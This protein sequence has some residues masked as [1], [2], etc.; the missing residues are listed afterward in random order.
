MPIFPHRHSLSLK[1]K[2]TGV[3]LLTMTTV[4][5]I[6]HLPW[7]FTSRRNVQEIVSQL[8]EESF[9]GAQN[10]TAAFFDNVLALQHIILSSIKN[11]LIALEEPD[12]Q[13]QLYLDLLHSHENLTWVQIG[14]ANGDFL[15]AQRRADGLYNLDRRQWGD[16][17]GE[18]GQPGSDLAAQQ[19]ERQRQAERFDQTSDRANQFDSPDWQVETYEFVDGQKGWQQVDQFQ[20][21]EFY[22]APSRP[23][24]QTALATP[25]KNVWTDVYRFR[26]GNV[27]GLDAAVTYQDPD[28]GVVQGVVSISFGLRRISEY[29][30]DI[31]TPSEGLLFIMD[32]D[33]NLIAA[34]DP[35]V[36]AETFES[37]TEAALQSMD[38]V[39]HPLLQT[40]DQALTDHSVVLS[41]LTD[42]Q[43]FSE[44]DAATGERYYIAVSPLGRLDWTIGSI[45]PEDVFLASVN[46]NQ[47]RLLFV[48]V[49][50]L[51]GTMMV[52]WQISDRFLIR[53]II[54][55]SD[56][57][58][59]M[60]NGEFDSV[61][62]G[63][64]AQRND[65][66]G[67]L[68]AVFQNMAA[69]IGDREKSLMAQLEDLRDSG[70]GM[71]GSQ[72]EV[73]YYQ[74]LTERA[75]RLR[76]ATPAARTFPPAGAMSAYYR[77]LKERAEAVR[78]TRISGAAVEQMLRGEAYLSSLPDG[79]LR[80]LANSAARQAYGTNTVIFQEGEAA[81][82]VYAI[83]QGTVEIRSTGQ[84][85]PLRRLQA[86]QLL[87]DLS[88][89][90]DIPHTTSAHTR[91]Q[92]VLYVIDREPFSRILRQNPQVIEAVEQKL[93][94]H[95]DVLSDAQ[96]WFG[97]GDSQLA[98]GATWIDVISQQLRQWWHGQLV[99]P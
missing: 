41:N 52:L 54:A 40:V 45:T 60:E 81:T 22:Y 77:A 78:S 3:I 97:D 90:L 34:S 24:Y 18:L 59:A 2:L 43:E 32:A 73:A 23:Y 65:E 83:A 1:V 71:A 94:H 63:S 51:G 76:S 66:L 31:R 12:D 72:L 89:M 79:D 85:A 64:T 15:G 28:S 84:D 49:G 74:A 55:V 86:G 36:L 26:T 11:D 67:Q 69:V 75:A 33:G 98:A 80:E 70:T 14:F 37:E 20:R 57:A 93:A 56:A 61:A 35:S 16:T 27:V 13:G 44:Y 50:L 17:L 95:Q 42:I 46:R 82:A 5:A 99:E 87:G 96:L 39:K 21:N 92:A 47:R 68:A 53:P 7:V 19:A 62:L 25:G 4:A 6:V 91:D 88:L 10:D 8:H 9:Q 48:I 29:L 38:S 58:A 30:A